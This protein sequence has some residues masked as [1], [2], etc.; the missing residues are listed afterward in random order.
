[1]PRVLTFLLIG[2]TTA[3]LSA[4]SVRLSVECTYL[5]FIGI[6]LEGEVGNSPYQWLLEA[7]RSMICPAELHEAMRA[8]RVGPKTRH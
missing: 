2:V 5:N 3:T 4:P 7:P 1:M 8:R 6:D